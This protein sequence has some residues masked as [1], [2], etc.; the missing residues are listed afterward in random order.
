MDESKWV[1]QDWMGNVLFGGKTFDTFE[2]AWSWVYEKD[3]MPEEGS[4][5]YDEHWYDDYYV[6]EMN[7]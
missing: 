5:E 3:P 6:V 1:I 4:P 7:Q 2:D